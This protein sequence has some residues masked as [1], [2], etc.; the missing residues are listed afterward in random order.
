[1][2]K[3]EGNSFQENRTFCSTENYKKKSPDPEYY[4]RETIRL[5]VKVR[6][7]HNKAKLGELF[8]PDLKRLSRQLLAAK[9]NKK[10]RRLLCG[11]YYIMKANARQRSNSM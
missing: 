2:G 4:N 1:M 3:L 7:A 8:R 6:R 11:Q 10:A 9:N 5:K